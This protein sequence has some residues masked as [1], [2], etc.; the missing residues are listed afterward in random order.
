MEISVIIPVYNKAPYL[1]KCFESIFQQTFG[2][3][4]V[5][6]VDDG[7]TDGSGELCDEWAKKDSRLHVIHTVNGGV[8]AARRIGVA[9]S[10]GKYIMFSDADDLFMPDALSMMHHQITETDADEVIAT[11]EDQYGLRVV[12]HHL[13]TRAARR[14]SECSP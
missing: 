7:S 11:Y 6:A 1:E 12:G 13:Q 10:H 4:E 5:V 14:M 2:E 9:H 3:F 8:T